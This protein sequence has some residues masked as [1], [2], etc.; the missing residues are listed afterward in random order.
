MWRSVGFGFALGLAFVLQSGNAGAIGPFGQ[1]D[2]TAVAEQSLV[3]QVKK[4]TERQKCKALNRCR[5]IYTH[6]SNKL[7]AQ[8]K[9]GEIDEKCVKPYQKC[10]H[11][12]FAGS[13]WFFTR[14]FNPQY[15]DCKKYPNR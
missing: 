14:W 4:L 2:K 7:E 13:D 12:N 11:S 15:L 8:H 6:C 3:I 10:I 5:Q 9:A 1:I